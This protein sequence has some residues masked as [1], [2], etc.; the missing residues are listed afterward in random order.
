[1]CRVM[2]VGTAVACLCGVFFRDEKLVS[3]D[4]AQANILG[5]LGRISLRGVLRRLRVELCVDR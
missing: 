1:M 4:A 5:C 2:W 3:D